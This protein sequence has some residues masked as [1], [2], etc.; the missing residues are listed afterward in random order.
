M[1]SKRSDRFGWTACHRAVSEII[2]E[3]MYSRTS[4]AMG[5]TGAS[6]RGGDGHLVMLG[7]LII[8]IF[9]AVRS[10]IPDGAN[11]RYRGL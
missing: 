5:N 11:W 6:V 10:M 2:K 9:M 3:E 7:A 1:L 4:R 8:D